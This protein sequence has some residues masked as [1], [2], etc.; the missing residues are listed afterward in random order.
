MNTNFTKNLGLALI[1]TVGLS[2][3]ILTPAQSLGSNS[4]VSPS[5]FLGA[6]PNKSIISLKTEVRNAQKACGTL[7]CTHSDLVLSQVNK[8]QEL[9]EGLEKQLIARAISTAEN[10]WPDTILEGP[11]ETD[12]NIRVIQI[13]KLTR[14]RK[15][16]GYRLIVSAKA[17]EIDSCEYDSIT[18]PDLNRC[19]PGH[20][21]EALFISSDLK[22]V[23]V[24]DNFYADFIPA[25]ES[26]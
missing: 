19:P 21:V 13:E 2:S 17:W 23:F 18:Q 26:L 7:D 24:D 9:P 11:Y 4:A 3:L 15:T 16:L 10:H 25:K 5:H 20:I 8:G 14:D 22:E 1:L 12:F 6:A